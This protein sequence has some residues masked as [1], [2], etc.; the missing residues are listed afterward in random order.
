[1]SITHRTVDLRLMSPPLIPL[2]SSIQVET[3]P[4]LLLQLATAYN[5]YT[6]G[7]LSLR[8]ILYLSYLSL[9]SAAMAVYPLIMKQWDGCP[10]HFTTYRDY[11]HSSVDTPF[12]VQVH[13]RQLLEWVVA[14]E[15][16]RLLG[17]P[18]AELLQIK[19]REQTLHATLQLQRDVS[20]M[21]SNLNVVPQ[22]TYTVQLL[23]F[24]SQF[25]ARTSF[26]LLLL[27]PL[28]RCP[29][30]SAPLHTWQLWA[31]GTHRMT[32]VVPDWLFTRAPSAPDFMPV[33]RACPVGSRLLN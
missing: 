32:L 5:N 28:R 23:V 21:S 13:H 11:E 29:A 3:D 33:F 31:S 10:Y 1:M 4:S 2:P 20:L 7:F 30:F 8:R 6:I 18:P 16:V 14:P 22:Y 26:H 19:S 25:L 9:C 12:G 24:C 17:R 27:I 15:S